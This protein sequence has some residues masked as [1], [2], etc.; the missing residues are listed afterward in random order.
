LGA[1]HLFDAIAN[2]DN[3]SKGKPHPELFCEALGKLAGEASRCMAVG[4]TPY[5]T[6]AAKQLGLRAAGV[7]TGGFS[8]DELLKAGCV[9][10]I[11][12]IKELDGALAL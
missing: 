7:L 2:G 1:L 10:V 6:F 9:I 5:D 3:T 12:Q 11:E 8:R 4:D